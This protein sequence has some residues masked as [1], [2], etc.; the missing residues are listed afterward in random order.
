MLGEVGAGHL[1]TG[2][3]AGEQAGVD[4]G[5]DGVVHHVR[6]HRR[7]HGVGEADQR[8]PLLDAGRGEHPDEGDEDHADQAEAEQPP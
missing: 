8:R 3:V 7:P 4:V 6:L 5:A 2:G 1:A